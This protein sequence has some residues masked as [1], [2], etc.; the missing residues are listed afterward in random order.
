MRILTYLLA[1]AVAVMTIGMGVAYAQ[2][3]KIVLLYKFDDEVEGTVKDVSGQ[4]NHGTVTDSEWT[5]DGK[6]GGAIEFNGSSSSI[7]IPHSNS[8]NIGGDEISII[9]W[10][11]PNSFP[12]GHPPIARK[13]HVAGRV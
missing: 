5:A 3:D 10:Y 11:K 1:I 2:N 8:L 6:S 12:G 9:A 4:G 7:E 13:G